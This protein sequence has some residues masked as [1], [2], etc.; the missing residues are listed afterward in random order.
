M[1]LTGMTFSFI[2]NQ[3][4]VKTKN[5]LQNNRKLIVTNTQV[6]DNRRVQIFT[7]KFIKTSHQIPE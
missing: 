1:A 2:I 4:K 3:Q 7:K 5:L 6:V